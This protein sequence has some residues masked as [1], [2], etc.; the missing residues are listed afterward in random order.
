MRNM[1]SRRGIRE[2]VVNLVSFGFRLWHTGPRSSCSST[3]AFLPNP[4][5]EESLAA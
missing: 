4:Y 3:F 5:F 1:S 2:T